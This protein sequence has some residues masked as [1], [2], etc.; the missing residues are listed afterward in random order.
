MKKRG[1]GASML[2]R[3]P[4][5]CHLNMGVVGGGEQQP[6]FYVYDLSMYNSTIKYA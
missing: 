2:K 5:I 4:K 3:E 6:A 1:G